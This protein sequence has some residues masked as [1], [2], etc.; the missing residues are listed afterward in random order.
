[1][2]CKSSAPG[3]WFVA[4]RRLKLPVPHLA[5]LISQL[6]TCGKSNN[7][8]KSGCLTSKERWEAGMGHHVLSCEFRRLMAFWQ[9]VSTVLC[10]CSVTCKIQVQVWYQ[11]HW[12][13]WWSG[14]FPSLCASLSLF[15]CLSKSA[16]SDKSPART[17]DCC[18]MDVDR[19]YLPVWSFIQNMYYRVSYVRRFPRLNICPLSQ[20][21]L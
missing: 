12:G 18:V 11:L 10:A 6:A 3:A 20:L 2:N 5:P 4:S 1:M 21:L 13:L 19:L 14:V 16:W 7:P 8:G 9:Y 15:F 17:V